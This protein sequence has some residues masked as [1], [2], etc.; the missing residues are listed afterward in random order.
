MDIR[1]LTCRVNRHAADGA[2]VRYRICR[3][4]PEERAMEKG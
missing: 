4:E 2:E 3:A 1:K